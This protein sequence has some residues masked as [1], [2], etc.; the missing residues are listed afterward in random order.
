MSDAA[1]HRT[2]PDGD[3]GEPRELRLADIPLQ[4]TVELVRIDLPDVQREPLFE[5][6]MLPGCS[7]C[8]VRR[9]PSGDPI[10]RIDGSLLAL[11]RELAGCICVRRPLGPPAP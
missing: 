10:V 11:R 6:G 3:A 1:S 5:R 7:L 4:E 2:D 9:S 8:P